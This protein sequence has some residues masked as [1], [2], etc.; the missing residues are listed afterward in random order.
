MKKGAGGAISSSLIDAVYETVTAHKSFFAFY[1]RMTFL[2]GMLSVPLVLSFLTYFFAAG[3]VPNL[4]IPDISSVAESLLLIGGLV[5]ALIIHELSH[6]VILTNHGVRATSVGISL[7]GVFGGYVQADMERET[8]RRLK[9]PFFSCGVG[10]GLLAFLVLSALGAVV[11]PTIIPA[12]VAF[13]WFTVLNALPAPLMDGGKIFESV[14]EALRI[15]KHLYPISALIFAS[16]M[17]AI[18]YHLVI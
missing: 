11:F 6:L 1:E 15:E 8:Y 7:A 4:L 12:A 3:T 5:V 18:I 16:W 2:L 17:A 9:A 10:S 14:L 13:F